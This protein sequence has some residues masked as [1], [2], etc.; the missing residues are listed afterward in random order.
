MRARVL[1]S[2]TMAHRLWDKLY[3][4]EKDELKMML[5]PPFIDQTVRIA[6]S[7]A[8]YAPIELFADLTAHKG[9]DILCVWQPTL[10]AE[11]KL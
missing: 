6:K 3:G 9:A 5:K 7:L 1:N 10:A 11:C 2:S 4:D 8:R